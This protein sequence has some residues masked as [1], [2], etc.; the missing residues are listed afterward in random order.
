MGLLGDLFNQFK[1]GLKRTQE[2]VLAP[3]GRLLGLRRL[4]EAQ[5]EE[6]EDLLL[7]ADLGLRAVDQLMARLRA[8]LQ[9]GA[10]IDP[11]QV[12]KDELLRLLHQSPAT[13]DIPVVFFT[14]RSEKM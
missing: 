4:D 5:L 13:R 1:K 9:G 12:L 11:K 6:L 14:A 7:Q 8:E 10:D 3:M 2:L